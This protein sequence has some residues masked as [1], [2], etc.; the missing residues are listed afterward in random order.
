MTGLVVALGVV[1]LGGLGAVVRLVL[2][3]WGNEAVGGWPA[4][5]LVANVGA[6]FALG[7]IHGQFGDLGTAIGVGLL[8]ALSTWSTLALEVM[9]RIRSGRWTT[10]A[11]YL[12]TTLVVGVAAAWLGLQL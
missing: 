4:G 12:A 7:V 9:D 6:A 10:A 8:G 3:R 1:G 11:S 2:A 5:T